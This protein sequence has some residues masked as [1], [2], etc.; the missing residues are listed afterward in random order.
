MARSERL[1]LQSVSSVIEDLISIDTQLQQNEAAIGMLR[2]AQ[3]NAIQ[4]N[5]TWYRSHNDHS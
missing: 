4:L 1:S 5:E 3:M 2:I